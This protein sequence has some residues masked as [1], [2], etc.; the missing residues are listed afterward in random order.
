[1]DSMLA[2]ELKNRLEKLFGRSFPSSLLL[3]ASNVAALRAFIVRTVFTHD[4]ADLIVTATGQ[5]GQRRS[6][7]DSESVLLSELEKLEK[8]VQEI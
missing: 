6:P 3:D 4:G 2:V 7:K 1:M 5:G 8:L